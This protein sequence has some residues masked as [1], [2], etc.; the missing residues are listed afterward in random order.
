MLVILT[1]KVP[2]V[3][4]RPF[5]IF[6]SHD[7]R[8]CPNV[9]DSCVCV[10]VTK[11]HLIL[12]KQKKI[13]I[14]NVNVPL[15]KFCSF[16]NHLANVPWQLF[17]SWMGKDQNLKKNYLSK[18]QFNNISVRTFSLQ[19]GSVLVKNSLPIHAACHEWAER[20]AI[21]PPQGKQNRTK[22]ISLMYLMIF[23]C[24]IIQDKRSLIQQ[25]ISESQVLTLAKEGVGDGV[26]CF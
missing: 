22:Q 1:T 4:F 6:K 8:L 20:A 23:K 24:S 17:S 10:C 9:H 12:M 13:K 7:F 14:Q 26:I 19:F 15:R 16:G 5:N 2:S 18:L 11:D 3:I 25:G 21:I